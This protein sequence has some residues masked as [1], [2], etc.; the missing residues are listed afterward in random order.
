MH[1]PESRFI[2]R[3]VRMPV[4]SELLEPL[5]KAGYLLEPD[6]G[7]I[8]LAVDRLIS[9][10]PKLV[11]VSFPI[12]YGEGIRTTRDVSMWEQFS[13]AAFLQRHWADNQVST[14]TH[15]LLIYAGELYSDI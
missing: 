14:L 3:R 1:Y 12:D 2:I 13:L 15:S 6:Q 5:Q 8:A 4:D 10:N 7:A 9:V 11:V